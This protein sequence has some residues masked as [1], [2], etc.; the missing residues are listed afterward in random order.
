MLLTGKHE[1]YWKK[2]GGEN[3]SA[4]FKDLMVKIFDYSGEKRPTIE[5]IQN[6]PWLKK[7]YNMKQTRESL[8]KK[9]SEK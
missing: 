3:L 5:D 8:I 4:E 9:L 7:S 2:V 1:K 6:H